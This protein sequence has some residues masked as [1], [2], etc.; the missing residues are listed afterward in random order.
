MEIPFAPLSQK[1][2]SRELR[3]LYDPFRMDKVMYND[4][5]FAERVIV[6]G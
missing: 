2:L 4:D 6:T 5:K 3:F 1:V